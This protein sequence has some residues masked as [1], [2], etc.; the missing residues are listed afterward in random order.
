[1]KKYNPNFQDPRVTRRVNTSLDWALACLSPTKPRQWSTRHIDR[2]FGSQHNPLSK[3]MRQH[4]LTT[5]DI[6]YN[7]LTHKSKQY[8]LNLAG[9]SQLA[10][11]VGRDVNT[12]NLHSQRC[13]SADTLYGEQIAQGAFEYTEK[14]NRLWNDI[15]FLEN[16]IRKPLFENYGYIHEYD[17]RTAAPTL[18][19]QLAQQHRTKPLP[20]VKDYVDHSRE[21]RQ[22]LSERIGVDVNTAKRLITARCAGARFGAMNA[23]A[24]ELQGRWVAYERLKTDHWFNTVSKEIVEMWSVIKS[25]EDL[26][27]LTARIKWNIYFREELRVMR[28]VHSSLNKQGI[29]Y[30]HEHDGWRSR[31]AVDMR[32]LKLHVNK[33]TG[34]WVD[35]ECG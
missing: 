33:Q 11:Y 10:S 35:F 23:I 19:Y 17:I 2:Q 3:M 6:Y 24:R 12:K 34:Y 1:M 31:E 25:S 13:T 20:A 18:L 21:H 27:R 29:T 15:Q 7:P 14:S 16:D 30:F 8:L 26:P 5:H 9:A 28:S 22:L 32:K 4:L